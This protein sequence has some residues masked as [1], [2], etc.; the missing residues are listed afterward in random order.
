MEERSENWHVQ[1]RG[2]H[3]DRHY[4]IFLAAAHAVICWLMLAVLKLGAVGYLC[5]GDYVPRL[6]NNVIKHTL[7][8]ISILCYSFYLINHSGW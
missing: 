1:W 2:M 6:L 3:S 5:T 7:T 8:T 4:I